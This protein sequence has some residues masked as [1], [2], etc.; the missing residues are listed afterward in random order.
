MA[1][2][3]NFVPNWTSFENQGGG[4]AAADLD[5]DGRPEL[6]VLR[7]DHLTPGTNRGFYRV[8]KALDATGPVTGEWGDWI[9]IP[10]W[11]SSDEQGANL[12]VAALGDPQ[13]SLVVV[14]VDR[15]VPGPNAGQYRVRRGLDAD[16]K[17]TPRELFRGGF[18][19]ETHGPYLSQFF[20]RPTSMGAQPLSQ[21]LTT[22]KP[23]QDFMTDP[24]SWF[25]VRRR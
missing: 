7:V 11:G 5:G 1:N 25:D 10:A 18:P 13:P 19:G 3:W 12:A 9:E 4:V 17:V 8:G 6:I 16:G 15:R 20:V 14:R 2:S 23:G 22:F 24:A 21:Q